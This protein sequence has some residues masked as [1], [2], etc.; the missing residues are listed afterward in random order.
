MRAD[1]AAA[2]AAAALAAA[3]G[4]A[5]LPPPDAARLATLGAALATSDVGSS[6]LAAAAAEAAKAAEAL[7]GARGRKRE[8]AA[9]A[10]ADAAAAAV[11][12][13]CARSDLDTA[14]AALAAVES[15]PGGAPAAATLR[16][17]VAAAADAALDA[18]LV[19]T[20]SSLS[21]SPAAAAGLA[22]ARALGGEAAERAVSRAAAAVAGGLLLPLLRERGGVAITQSESQFAW[23]R[24]GATGAVDAAARAAAWLAPS[25]LRA[26]PGAGAA[27][28]ASAWPP[29]AAA[30]VD[31]VLAPA[32]DGRGREGGRAAFDSAAAS[33]SRLEAAA[34][35]AHLAPAT[36]TDGGGRLAAYA[37]R[38]VDRELAGLR[39]DVVSAARTLLVRPPPPDG[40]LSPA[41]VPL[42]ARS[43]DADEW[44]AVAAAAAH[45][46]PRP[47]DWRNGGGAGALDAPLLAAGEYAVSPAGAA[48]AALVADTIARASTARPAA[49]QALARGAADAVDLAGLLPP[50]A[51]PASLRALQP[52]A[53]FRNDCAAV[54]DAVTRGLAAAARPLADRAAGAPAALADAAARVRA[55]GDTALRAR[56]EADAGELAACLEGARG[57]ARLA[58]GGRARDAGRAVAAAA[59]GLARAGASLR[60]TLA[61]RERVAVAAALLDAVAGAAARD[62]LTLHHIASD[63]ADALPALLA[64][65]AAD[66]PAAALGLLLRARSAGGVADGGDVGTP[67]DEDVLVAAVEAAAPRLATLRVRQKGEEGS[68]RRAPPHTPTPSPTPHPYPLS[69]S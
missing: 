32:A 4:D 3:A 20:P 50:A 29:V 26:S 27:V 58:D 14:M 69:A 37:A 22:A 55:A 2:A 59:A 25:L 67:P 43:K 1:A 28:G 30:V 8:A 5:L 21:V 53:L 38:V 7:D 48:V 11:A 40:G 62:L 63:D 39:L 49:A 13:A 6:P 17:L 47:L 61:P 19:A 12:D 51:R 54:G 42:P 41:G 9:A 68:H 18:G 24:G 64:P 35:A 15:G 36:A 33:A 31:L 16:P 65:V 66:G 60:G 44:R 46:G 34:E 56:V 45:R 23:A 57:F 52:L 10:A